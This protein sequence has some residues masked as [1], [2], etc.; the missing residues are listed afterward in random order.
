MGFVIVCC[1][2]FIVIGVGGREGIFGCAVLLICS[3]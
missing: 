1:G 3:F 2:G